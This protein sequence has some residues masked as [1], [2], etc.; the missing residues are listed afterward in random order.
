MMKQRIFLFIAS[1]FAGMIF[2]LTSCTPGSCFEETNASLKAWF[3]SSETDKILAPDSITVYGLNRNSKKIYNKTAKP[4]KILLPLDA[5][6]RNCSFIIRINGKTDT[7]TIT[8][9]TFPH[10]ISKECGYTFYHSIDTPVYSKNKIKA[11][12]VRKATIT[13]LSE[14]NIRIYY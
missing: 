13:T 8:Y 5:S 9:S 1:L 6:S 14:E 7:L 4:Q 12:T 10:L 11:L 3:Y 2:F